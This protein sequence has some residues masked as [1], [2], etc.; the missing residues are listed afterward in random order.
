MFGKEPIQTQSTLKKIRF[1]NESP[2]WFQS[3]IEWHSIED[4]SDFL[5]LGQSTETSV[6]D[7]RVEPELPSIY[8]DWPSKY[9]FTSIN[10]Y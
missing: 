2:N 8:K 6:Y 1:N 9:K 3:F 4:E 10:L 5:Q 7:I